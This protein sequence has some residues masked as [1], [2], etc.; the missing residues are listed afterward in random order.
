[1]AVSKVV[2]V[3][4]NNLIVRIDRGVAG[5]GIT[6][7]EAVEIDNSLYLVF[8][9]TD[10][11]TETVGPVGTIQYIGQAPI[12]VNGSTISLST[13][14]VNL[15]GT[16]ATT[17]AN[18]RTN[19]NAANQDTTITAGTVATSSVITSSAQRPLLLPPGASLGARAQSRPPPPLQLP[20]AAAQPL[21]AP[22]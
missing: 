13:V 15:G 7:V 22:A 4:G 2:V 17:A 8:S 3:D 12:V 6:D 16:G 5:R 14:P 21:G 20:L 19:L 18:A 10:G 11:T 9:F 1:M